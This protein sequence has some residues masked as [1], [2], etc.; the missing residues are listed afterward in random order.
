MRESV[1]ST[2]DIRNSEDLDLIERA[3]LVIDCAAE[4]SVQAGATGD[5]TQ[6]INTNLGGTLKC[7]EFARQRDAAF[8][9]LSTSRVYPID[10]LNRLPFEESETRY[11][12][13]ASDEP[14]HSEYGVS[15]MFSLD[16]ARSFYGAGKL[17]S[18]LIIQEYVYNCQMPALIN[19]CGIITGPWQMGKVDQG[20]VTLWV[21]NHFF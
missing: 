16:G 10:R 1:L 18:E 14:G 2:E 7:L 4:P 15:E 3:D 17:A 5:P 8:L 6:I 12:W 11:R 21:A 19:R 20:V 9:F 13:Q